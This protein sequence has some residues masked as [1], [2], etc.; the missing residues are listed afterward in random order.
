MQWRY[1]GWARPPTRWSWG[2]DDPGRAVDEFD[3]AWLLCQW[4][5]SRRAV[6]TSGSEL[7]RSSRRRSSVPCAR[8]DLDLARRKALLKVPP[9]LT[10]SSSGLR[11]W[12]PMVWGFAVAFGLVWLASG[13][14]PCVC[15]CALCFPRF[16]FN[17]IGMAKQH[18]GRRLGANMSGV[19]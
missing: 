18:A 19:R 4:N 16:C 5:A 7:E 2:I 9:R 1:N 10:V 11:I 13:E 17:H 6:A 8:K 15:Y 12:W 14:V 3:V